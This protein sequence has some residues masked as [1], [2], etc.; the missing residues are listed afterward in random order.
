MQASAVDEESFWAALE[1]RVSREMAGVDECRRLGMWCDGFIAETVDLDAS[2]NRIC[3]Q[4]WVGLG[5]GNQEAWTFELLL[6]ATVAS[7]EQVPWSELLPAD[8][9]TQ[10]LRIDSER[11]HL[12]VAPGEAVDDAA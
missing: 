11:K 6:P 8:G 5:P 1:Y 10:W 12:V 4:A 7:R 3:G 2:P 9:V